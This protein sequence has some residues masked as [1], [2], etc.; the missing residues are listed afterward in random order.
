MLWISVVRKK[1]TDTE[2]TTMPGS[3]PPLL[4]SPRWSSRAKRS[5]ILFALALA[6][7]GAVQ[8]GSAWYPV[9]AATVLAYLLMPIVN[10][11]ER[12]LFFVPIR[13][14]RR[15]IAVLFTFA[16]MIGGLTLFG[17]LIVP[18]LTSQLEEFLVNLPQL[19][20]ETGRAL[21]GELRK[22]ISVGSSS[23]EPW[24]ALQEAFTASN[25]NSAEAGDTL[26]NLITA[27]LAPAANLV[28]GVF[29]ALATLFLT[30]AMMFYAMKDG[31]GF[32]KALEKITPPDYHGDVRFIVVELGKIWNAYLRGQ[33]ILGLTM[34]AA[35]FTGA[36]IIGLPQPLVL[37]LLAGLL[38]FIPNVGPT[39][40][41]TPAIIMAL[42]TPST[43]I[44]GL[45]GGLLFGLIVVA[46]YVG[47][48]AIEG[49]FLVPRVMGYTLN[50]HPFVILVALVFGAR[51]GGVLG[52]ILAAPVAATLRLLAA[53]LWTKIFDVDAFGMTLSYNGQRTAGPP[54][55]GGP[56][57]LGDPSHNQEPE[58]EGE[59]ID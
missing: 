38:E 56:P 2:K 49:L 50:L 46:M 21:E 5:A 35:T 13:E 34:G 17:L 19:L 41:A 28:G 58:I 57:A 26:G 29:S 6:F 14:I 36:S 40:A 33:V 52:V 16:T 47:L 32:I 18:P 30:L 44:P 20:E 7:Y 4:T 11:F 45:E 48:Q 31:P 43:T 59:I 51:F 39:L 15:T 24:T 10:Q 22:P 37:G 25:G 23:F 55:P 9:L 8:L 54:L 42:V 12:W 1:D 53:Y 3:P 27:L